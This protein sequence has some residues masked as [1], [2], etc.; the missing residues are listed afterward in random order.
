VESAVAAALDYTRNAA[1]SGTVAVQCLVSGGMLY[2]EA[3]TA[4]YAIAGNVLVDL[5]VGAG[6]NYTFTRSIAGAVTIGVA[7]GAGLSYAVA[8]SIRLATASS[9]VILAW[10]AEAQL[11]YHERG[12]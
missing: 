7:V 2:A 3:G 1:I 6:L 8:Q 12:S 11:S 9:T 5:L 10:R 4:E